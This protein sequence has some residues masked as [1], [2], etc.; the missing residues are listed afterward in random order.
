MKHIIFSS[1]ATVYGTPD[2]V[3][4]P[5][6]APLRPVNPYGETKLAVEK[7]LHAAHQADPSW[8]IGILRY[9]NPVGA[10]ESG[11]IGEDPK[12]VPENLMPITLFWKQ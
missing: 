8:R 9:F 10:H 1:S 7:I 6:T 5:E 12:G 2:R 11:L 4:V 3:P